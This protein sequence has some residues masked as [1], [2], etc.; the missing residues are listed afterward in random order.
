M[1]ADLTKYRDKLIGS[2]DERA[3]SPVI[4]VI[5]MVAI[6]VILAAVIAAFVLDMGDE[7]GDSAPTAGTDISTNSDWGTDDDAEEQ[8]AFLSHQSGDAIDRNEALINVRDE[9]GQ[10]LADFDGGDI[11]DSGDYSENEIGVEMDGDFDGGTTI[12]VIAGEESDILETESEKLNGELDSEDVTVQ[13]IHTPT[14][15]TVADHTVSVPDTN[16]EDE[17]EG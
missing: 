15:T 7:M 4:G 11:D 17:T 10:L 8:L 1:D 13:L 6:T 9:N 2:E 16:L 14:D 3:V 12:T 5:L